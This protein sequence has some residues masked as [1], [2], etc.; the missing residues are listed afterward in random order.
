M[1]LNLALLIVII[2]L[3]LLLSM[4]WPPDSPWSPWWRTSDD[5]IVESFKL[6]KLTSKDTVYDLGSGDGRTL[7]IAARKFK[8]RTIGIEIDPLRYFISKLLVKFSGLSDRV[9]VRRENFLKS[10]FSDATVIF[11]YLVPN[12]LKRLKPK[13]LGELK[14]G[15]RIVSI[16]YEIDLP[17]VNSINFKDKYKIRLYRVSKK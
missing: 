12:A 10:N 7:V 5:A 17:V 11:V 2:L 16:K 3:F 8:A 13:F 15:V 6:A 4:I 9:E 1:I 14:P